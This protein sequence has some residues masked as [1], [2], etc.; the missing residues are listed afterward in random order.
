LSVLGKDLGVLRIVDGDLD[1]VDAVLVQALCKETAENGKIKKGCTNK[2]FIALHR[3]ILGLGAAVA[4]CA[5]GLGV[6]DKVGVVEVE[7]KVV[8][9][10]VLLLPLDHAK[11]VVVDEKDDEVL[12]QTHGRLELLRVHHEAA[13]AAHDH[14]L[15][16]WVDQLGGNARRQTSTHGGEGIVQQDRV[17]NV[18]LVV[19]R[20]PELVHAVVERE[21]CVVLLYVPV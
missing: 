11:G 15:T 10:A 1:E 12:E 17:G 21:D 16:L 9:A 8:E 14:D 7:T 4:L 20:E 19:A 13:V 3:Q 6:L 18:R 5:V 2:L